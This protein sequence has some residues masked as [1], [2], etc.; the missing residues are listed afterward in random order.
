MV[1]KTE[2]TRKIE[3]LLNKYNINLSFED[4]CSTDFLTKLSQL[5]ELK[6]ES[7]EFDLSELSMGMSGDFKIAI[8]EGSTMVRV[9]T[10]IFGE[11]QY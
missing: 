6:K 5:E 10:S 1:A 3:G 2:E 8:R 7:T 4:L 9:G 11:R